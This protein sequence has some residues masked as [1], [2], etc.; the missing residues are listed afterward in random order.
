VK[1]NHRYTRTGS[2]IRWYTPHGAHLGPQRLSTWETPL[3]LSTLYHGAVTPNTGHARDLIEALT[4][5]TSK[6]SA[7]TF[8]I[9]N[10]LRSWCLC[11]AFPSRAGRCTLSLASDSSDKQAKLLRSRN[12][13]AAS[14]TIVASRRLPMPRVLHAFAKPSLLPL[15]AI[16]S[17]Q[18]SDTIRP[19]DCQG[20]EASRRSVGPSVLLCCHCPQTS[21]PSCR[22][23]T[24]S[25][26]SFCGRV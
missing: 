16:L 19:G 8:G 3:G 14:S 7:K 24:S 18:C 2:S 22:D 15:E 4:G 10:W 20:S 26:S 1:T 25:I 6:Q 11:G 9:N 23:T 12:L 17:L 5:K 13:S 21:S